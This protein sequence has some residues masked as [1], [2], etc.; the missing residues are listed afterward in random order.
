[1]YSS[2]VHLN[3]HVWDRQIVPTERAVHYS[4]TTGH[5][6]HAE[7]GYSR[8]TGL[9]VKTCCDAAAKLLLRNGSTREDM[10]LYSCKVMAELKTAFS[11]THTVAAS[12]IWT[13][14]SVG[15]VLE[16]RKI[17]CTSTH[18]NQCMHTHPAFCIFALGIQR[19]A[20]PLIALGYSNTTE[21]FPS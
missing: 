13:P 19:V 18:S 11:P 9:G 21:N 2:S 3:G 17:Y 6:R 7:L 8:Q 4:R 14:R 16:R 15:L 1:M 5:S 10:L 12:I 20:G